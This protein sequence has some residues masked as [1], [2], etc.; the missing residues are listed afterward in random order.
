MRGSLGATVTVHGRVAPGA[1]IPRTGARTG[2]SI[3]VTGTTGRAAAGLE[4]LRTGSEAG[5]AGS[6]LI[7][8]FLYPAPRVRE[9]RS[10]AGIATAMIDVSDGLHVDLS[11]LLAASEQGARLDAG[12]VPVADEAEECVGRDRALEYALGG[13][14]DYELCFTVPPANEAAFAD[15][16]SGWHCSVSRLGVVTAEQSVDWFSDGR[17]IRPGDAW[18]H[19]SQAAP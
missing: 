19:F 6:R 18:E 2:D 14:D 13:G 16:V 3:W 15:I 11:R 17:R 5:S 12:A 1:A 7:E 9:G 10:L 4:L 8:A